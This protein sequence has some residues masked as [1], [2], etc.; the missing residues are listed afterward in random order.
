MTAHSERFVHLKEKVR[1][2]CAAEWDITMKKAIDLQYMNASIDESLRLSPPAPI[3]YL[4][5]ILVG[6]NTIDEIFYQWN[7]DFG[8]YLPCGS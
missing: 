5:S 3:E 1:T 8:Q 7:D 4:R 2:S 6:G